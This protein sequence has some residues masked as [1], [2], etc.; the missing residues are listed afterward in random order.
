MS[1]E[2]L[3][4]VLDGLAFSSFSLG[5]VLSLLS[6]KLVLAGFGCLSL[7]QVFGVTKLFAASTA[8]F[9]YFVPAAIQLDVDAGGMREEAGV[10]VLGTRARKNPTV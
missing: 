2:A 7:A 8:R 4:D 1:S 6:L 9:V 5:S 10:H 3:P